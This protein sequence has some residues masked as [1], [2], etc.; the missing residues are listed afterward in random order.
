[1]K[2]Y[3]SPSNQHS[4]RYAL[5]DTNER[6]QCYAIAKL[7]ASKLKEIGIESVLPTIDSS[8][9]DRVAEA[10]KMGDID[11]YLPIHTNA[12]NG[13]VQGTRMFCYAVG[14]DGYRACTSIFAHVNAI[15]PGTSSNIRPNPT[16]YEV[17][18]PNAPTAYL[19]VEFH[20][21]ATSSVWIQTHH[22]EIA[23]AIR[24][25][26]AAYFG[27]SQ[28]KADEPVLAC[29]N[30]FCTRAEL[31]TMLWAAAGKPEAPEQSIADVPAD[32]W[33]RA[34]WNWAVKNVI[35]AGK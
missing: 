19:E 33:S 29:P 31:V 20:D 6:E 8:M 5:S 16:L 34:A 14:G 17:H 4:N 15:T 23:E 13:T 26:V 1:M 10:N 21:N 11:L 32:H 27:I 2:V 24:D 12:A 35:V 25:G 7:L 18:A 28:K 3:L 22:T 30:D 9:Y